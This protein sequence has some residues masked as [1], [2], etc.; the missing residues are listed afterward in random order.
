MILALLG[1]SGS[2]SNQIFYEDAE[3]LA[4]LPTF[5]DL[6][7]AYPGAEDRTG[8]EALYYGVTADS[9]EGFSQYSLLI[10][11]VAD[12]ARLVA[13]AF[14]AEDVRVWGP[15][16][17]DVYPG[18]YLRLEVSRTSAR[19]LYV[20]Q[21]QA[22]Q[23]PDGPWTEFV[24]GDV[25]LTDGVESGSI[26]WDQTA[27]DEAI[28]LGGEGTYDVEYTLD[29]G[30]QISQ[31]ADRLAVSDGV[32]RETTEAWIDVGPEGDGTYELHFRYDTNPNETRP[33]DEQ[34]EL[35]AQ[36][37]VQGAGRADA[38]VEGGDTPYPGL[39]FTQCWDDVGALTFQGDSEGV[40]PGEG[41]EGDC[42]FEMFEE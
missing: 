8:D 1:C 19:D 39:V 40:L 36:W 2:L 27:L 38:L 26:A 17:W 4:A 10:T 42:V 15:G 29:D 22:S 30:K 14:R 20:Y 12:T 18:S 23:F 9:L 16:A 5:D 37:D 28:D 35:M 11:S 24:S 7:V 25:W 6:A 13:P 32:E 34:V 41:V 33:L 3:F 21:F 31:R